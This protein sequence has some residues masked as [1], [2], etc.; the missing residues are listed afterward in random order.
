MAANRLEVIIAGDTRDIERAFKR[1]TGQTS[2]FGRTMGKLGKAAVL[3][4]GAA[5]VGGALAVMKVGFGEAMESAKVMAQT[6]AG[7]KSTGGAA[8]VTAKHV[9]DLSGKLLKLSGVDDEAI[10]SGQ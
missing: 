7:L 6:G 5:G 8:N 2:G 9:S 4:L 10:Q 3:G 1:A